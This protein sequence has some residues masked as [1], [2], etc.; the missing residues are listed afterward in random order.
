MSALK[1]YRVQGELT[2][3][4]STIV[5]ATSAAAAKTLAE[6]KPVQGLCHQCSSGD[7]EE[8]EWVTSGELDGAPAKLQVEEEAL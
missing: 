8:T 4:V 3:S 6:D 2:I 5:W 1:R 7:E